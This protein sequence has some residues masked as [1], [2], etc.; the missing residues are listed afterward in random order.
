VHGGAGGVGSIAVQTATALGGRVTATAGTP[1]IGFVHGPGAEWVIDFESGAFGAEP[2]DYGVALDAVGGHVN[3]SFAVLRRG[4]RLVTV[5]PRPSAD[6]AEVYGVDPVFIPVSPDRAQ[7]MRLAALV[8]DEGLRE[9][10]SAT[11]AL[12]HGWWAFESGRPGGRKPGKVVL[13]V[14]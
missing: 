1:G 6:R 8:D 5:Q 14:R 12:G 10:V 7:R 2:G 4:G 9:V 3:R 13:V 11:F